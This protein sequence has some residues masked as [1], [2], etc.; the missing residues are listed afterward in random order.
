MAV[1]SCGL[2]K[3][4]VRTISSKDVEW[5][6]AIFVM[7][8]DHRSRLQ[9]SFRSPLA[10]KLVAS[11][12]IPDDYEFMDPELVELLTDRIT[13]HLAQLLPEDLDEKQPQIS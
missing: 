13:A 5:A 2:S 11:L 4:A 1:R 8:A 3:Q 12:D 7:E 10:N 6:D 9:Q